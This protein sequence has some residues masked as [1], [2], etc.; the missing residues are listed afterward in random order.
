MFILE[1]ALTKSRVKLRAMLPYLWL[2]SVSL[3]FEMISAVKI[4]LAIVLT[5]RTNNKNIY[6][7][8]IYK[9]FLDYFD[10]IAV[11]VITDW[12]TTL[13]VEKLY[14]KLLKELWNSEG[15][16]ESRS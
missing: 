1:I 12:N 2:W 11:V 10:I 3:L 4:T 9:S 16:D 15:F 8:Y 14:I 13:M 5:I 7:N 6:K